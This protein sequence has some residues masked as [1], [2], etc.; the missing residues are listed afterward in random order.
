MA[1]SRR[2]RDGIIDDGTIDDGTMGIMSL[3]TS[4][5]ELNAE[6]QN[7]QP[8]E[9][10]VTKQSEKDDSEEAAPLYQQTPHEYSFENY[11]YLRKS[12]VW[13]CVED[14]VMSF[15]CHHDASGK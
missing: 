14:I 10:P 12:Q 9:S 1:V 13:R 8:G 6:L 3:S 5:A 4:N 7:L 11:S 15:E 2:I